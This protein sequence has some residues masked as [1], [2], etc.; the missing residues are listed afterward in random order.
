M[1]SVRKRENGL[2]LEILLFVHWNGSHDFMTL[3]IWALH[4][5]LF[6][7]IN[8]VWCSS[9][10][11]PEHN[12]SRLRPLNW[13]RSACVGENNSGLLLLRELRDLRRRSVLITPS[14]PSTGMWLIRIWGRRMMG[15]R[16]VKTHKKMLLWLMQSKSYPHFQIL[17]QCQFCRSKWSF[18]SAPPRE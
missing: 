18:Q 14:A 15:K 17:V 9:R 8:V 6:M 11:H 12:N 16:W 3:S 7:Q 2:E 10:K 4:L 13:I 5:M 1:V